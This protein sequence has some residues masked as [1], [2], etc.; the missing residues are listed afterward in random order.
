MSFLQTLFPNSQAEELNNELRSQDKKIENLT[1][2][3]TALEA[4]VRSESKKIN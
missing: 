3:L 1:E 4:Q 2:K